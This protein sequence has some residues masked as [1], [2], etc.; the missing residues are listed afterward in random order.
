MGQRAINTVY[1]DSSIIKG[2]GRD[3]EKEMNG[4]TNEGIV[5]QGE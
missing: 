3:Q 4:E 1:E 5:Q 2:E